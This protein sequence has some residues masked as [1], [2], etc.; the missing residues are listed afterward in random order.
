M[1]RERESPCEQFHR[2]ERV[3]GSFSRTFDLPLPVDPFSGKPFR[4]AKEGDKAHI[5]GNPPTGFEQ[6]PVYNLHYEITIRK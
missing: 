5:R 2:I 6:V 1:R 3:H 4:Y